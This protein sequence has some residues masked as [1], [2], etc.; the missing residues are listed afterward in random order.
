M[1]DD[2]KAASKFLEVCDKIEELEQTISQAKEGLRLAYMS[3]DELSLKL[4]PKV[5]LELM[6]KRLELVQC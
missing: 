6:E 1:T 4:K 2:Q 3:Y 5:L